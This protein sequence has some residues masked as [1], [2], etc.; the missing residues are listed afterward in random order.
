MENTNRPSP[1]QEPDDVP[2]TI[3]ERLKAFE[4]KIPERSPQPEVAEAEDGPLDRAEVSAEAVHHRDLL[5]DYE[6]ALADRI[7]DV[8]DDRRATASR[9]QRAWQHQ[10]EEIDERL[11]RHVA[12]FGGLLT[13]IAIFF[14]VALVVVYRH[15]TTPQPQADAE[16]SE[17][18]QELARLGDERAVDGEVRKKLVRMTAQIAE[19]A[20]AL[21]QLHQDGEQEATASIAAERAARERREAALSAEIR[22]LTAGQKRLA[23]TLALFGSVPRTSDI[24]RS[25]ESPEVDDTG[26]MAPAQSMAS[27][28]APAAADGSGTEPAS[29]PEAA[30]ASQG[31]AEKVDQG[32][33]GVEETG[34]SDAG[35]GESYAREESDTAA[36][37]SEDT[38]IAAGDIYALQLIGFFNEGSLEEFVAREP[39]PPQ[40]YSI[41]QTFKGRPWYVLIHS[42]HDDYAAAEKALSE[43]P[44]NLAALNPWIRPLSEVT[45]LQIIE[46]PQKHE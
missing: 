5:R 22:A 34:P 15:A 38:L 33:A 27:A 36:S 7:A 13:L 25:G 19:I 3:A 30:M 45:E 11:R 12:L 43:L 39:L 18:R 40:V 17:I 31:S 4:R 9:L 20:T 44:P 32:V 8:D 1:P 6:K 10:R 42:L 24:A 21:G 35:G 26:D 14:A 46:T 29:A 16:V 23:Q 28:R 2:Y 41:R 37:E